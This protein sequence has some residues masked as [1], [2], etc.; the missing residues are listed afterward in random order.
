[1]PP[2]APSISHQRQVSVGSSADRRPA[3]PAKL[4]NRDS[5]TDAGAR[6]FRLSRFGLDHQLCSLWVHD[7]TFS[8]EEVLFN[9]QAFGD[10]GVKLG[11]F[12]EISALPGE[13]REPGGRSGRDGPD[14]KSES[15]RASSGSVKSNSAT[16]NAG[17]VK[18]SRF[19][20]IAKPLPPELKARHPNLQLSVTSNIA[21]VFG[22]KNRSQVLLS[23]VERSECTTS[24]VEL[25]I[26]DQFLLRSDMWRLVTSELAG[27]TVYKG[28]KVLFL[29]TIKATIKAIYIRGKKTSSGYFSPSTIPIFRSE[30]G[31][32]VLFIQMSKEMWDF[33][34]EGT[35]DILFS[36]VINGF[37]P[38]LFKRWASVEAHH[39]VTIVLFTRVQ[40]DYS[41]A[42]S[43]LTA[44]NNRAL[45]RLLDGPS[46]EFQDFYRVVVNDMPSGQWTAIL[47][48]LK[49]EFRIFLRDVSI[50]PPRFPQSP[51]SAEEALKFTDDFPATI[52]GY[53][54]S[55]S[56]GNILEA[57]NVATSYLTYEH[58]GRDL[59][60]TGTSIVL[61][62]P[63]TGV[64]EVPFDALA[65]TSEVLTSRAIAI[66][67]ICLSPMPL[68][69][70]PLFKYRVPNDKQS[71]PGSAVSKDTVIRAS[72]PESRRLSTSISAGD[73]LAASFE[74]TVDQP[75]RLIRKVRAA[76]ADEWGYG[77]PH[78]IDISFWDPHSYRGS[79]FAQEKL[80]KPPIP[81]TLAEQSQPFV[82]KVRMY[83]IQMMGV[84]ESEQS[85]ITIPYLPPIRTT[86]QNTSVAMLHNRGLVD[87]ETSG[88][89]HLSPPKSIYKPHLLSPTN[90]GGSYMMSFKESK[91]NMM[92]APAKQRTDTLEW[93][94]AYDRS[95]FH[96]YPTS[97]SIRRRPK[98]MRSP[99]TDSTDSPIQ[100]RRSSKSSI[101]LW[102]SRSTAPSAARAPRNGER[103]EET[104]TRTTA[105]APSSTINPVRKSIIKSENRLTTPRISR[106]I[107]FALRGL[108]PA[109][110]AVPSTGVHVEHATGVPTTSGKGSG[111][112]SPSTP[113][114]D[115]P[116]DHNA[117]VGPS[118]IVS[119]R[120]RISKPSLSNGAEQM[121][122]SR[123][124]SIRA[125]TTEETP[126][127][128]R[129]VEHPRL[130]APLELPRHVPGHTHRSS[131]AL[132][133]GSTKLD[134][135]P[136]SAGPELIT[137]LSPDKIL[138][139]WIMPITPWNPPK[140]GPTRSSW[141]GRWQ[142]VYPRMPT[143]SSVKWKSLKSP[144][145][146]PITTEEFPSES[147]LATDYLQTPYMVYPYDE[148]DPSGTRKSREF[149]LREM[150]SLRLAR[151]FQIVVGKRIEEEYGLGNINIYDVSSLAVNGGTLFM[152]LGNI[153]HRLVCVSG[154]EIEVTR[155][156][157]K[158]FGENLTDAKDRAT[159]Y[160]PAV[161]T[162]LSS[163]Y[164]KS[165]IRLALPQKEYNWS[166]ADAF[167]AGHRDHMVNTPRQLGF[168]RTR[169]VLIP[170]EVP[171]NA[172][173]PIPSY[174]EDNEEEVHLLGIYQLTQIWQ[175]HRYI[176]PE[177]KRLQSSAHRKREQNP[178]NIL[179]QTSDPSVVVAAEL[180]KLLVDDPA[181]DNAP[182]QLLPDSE[183]FERSSISM[184]SLAQAIQGEKGVRMTDRRWHWRLHYNCFIGLELT[185]WIVQN[186]RDID[187]REEAV[188]FGNEMMK[189]GLFHHVQRRHN[190]RDGNYF[191]QIADEYRLAR[192]ES[193]SSWFQ[194]RKSDR[195]VP[196]TPMGDNIRDSPSSFH[197]K[198]DKGAEGPVEE[199][200]GE[201]PLKGKKVAIS[202]SKSMKYDL[203]PRKRSNRPEIMHL[204]YDRLHNPENCFHIELSWMNTTPK[205]IEDTLLSWASTADKYGLKL[206]EL[207][208]SEV[209]S[210]TETQIFRRPYPV[211]LKLQ[212]PEPPST[213]F[214]ATSFSAQGAK[215]RLFYH[216][217]ILK[218]FDFV[219]DFEAR[220]AFP[221]DVDVLYSWGEADYRFPQYV[222]RTGMVLA[223]ITDEGHFLL[224][225]NR[226]FSRHS[227]TV[228][229]ETAKF[230]RKEYSRPRSHTLDHCSPR[231]SPMVRASADIV[232]QLP[233]SQETKEHTHPYRLTDQIKDELGAFCR[234][235]EKLERFFSAIRAKTNA[236]PASSKVGPALAPTMESSIPTLELPASVVPRPPLAPFPAPKS[237]AP[238][239][240]TSSIDAVVH[241]SVTNSPKLDPLWLSPS[242]RQ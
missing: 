215:D 121:T 145:S 234:D 201:V 28:Q 94:D 139:P 63:G 232:P 78:W 185:T 77:I 19:L 103:I 5:R 224:L 92:P 194:P 228:A 141:F 42:D 235:E 97:R 106:S 54:T 219:L 120:E 23:L 181:L 24:H 67:L 131:F 136:H 43:A 179:Y 122:P 2:P 32:F 27:K 125:K 75:T 222:H 223:Q 171:S 30:S 29:G 138:A 225:A 93:M 149:V 161:K 142:H 102:D 239:T 31:R 98:A 132:K 209:S 135:G 66:D 189:L 57:M 69:S 101:S 190:F 148:V 64:F 11:D 233:Q 100:D 226:L 134:L 242:Q 14:L 25:V 52:A 166:Y 195:S 47:D 80:S 8:R 184:S 48:E 20:F 230:E 35:G 187:S 3:S 45:N 73:S 53:P 197:G 90:R 167:L 74:S 220:S 65:L 213:A 116:F 95:V 10:I 34:S 126:A 89:T 56:R 85:N 79:K 123:P 202:L 158:S 61:I 221:N 175:K 127:E 58:I 172:R 214:S 183:L 83:E 40:Y 159:S 26:R 208:V 76:Q 198:S 173:R 203:D 151:G 178:L 114:L 240:K 188:A 160:S 146:L 152:S 169:F 150:V 33:D 207:P 87:R 143:T 177:E 51:T 163:Q 238:S 91:K 211:K 231:L 206:V 165:T 16:P 154:G 70:V 110:R 99:N 68:H 105:A 113:L 82:P 49:R 7:E 88:G 217:A 17:K 15:L 133:G 38:E 168:W 50:P 137:K 21:N 118:T 55:A 128:S 241:S 140:H 44:L 129:A 117:L 191:Y 174:N 12:I 115:D 62:T 200:T 107:S 104:G 155:F 84:M 6:S 205:L 204:H 111:E 156:V 1:M 237:D 108:G 192:P 112:T 229:K 210:I 60:R 39:L 119:R 216:K 72:S 36:R 153:I 81:S 227:A 9:P 41:T 147:E 164:C 176:P 71:R 46:P 170:V 13:S 18:R 218:K 182:A 109:P 59:L 144:A 157:R 193:R 236:R 37:L 212:P 96:A 124:I 130:P 180:D 196:S 86:L 199:S 4:S 186:F 22:F 162:I